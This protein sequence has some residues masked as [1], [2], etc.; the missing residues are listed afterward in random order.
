M[1]QTVA[2]SAIPH[3]VAFNECGHEHHGS[4]CA[5]C[6][7]GTIGTLLLNWSY[8]KVQDHAHSRR[9]ANRLA[10]AIRALVKHHGPV[11]PGVIG[12]DEFG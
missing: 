10:A 3:Y 12:P 4:R 8:L 7:T 11:V 5:I 6:Y 1:A 2:P 9:D